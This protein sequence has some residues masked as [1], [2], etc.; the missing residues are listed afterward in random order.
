MSQSGTDVRQRAIAQWRAAERR[1][2]KLEALERDGAV[3]E[4]MI[5]AGRQPRLSAAIAWSHEQLVKS[6]AALNC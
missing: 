4:Q 6:V 2:N 5:A 1:V 3:R